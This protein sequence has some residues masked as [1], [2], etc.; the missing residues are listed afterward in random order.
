[1]KLRVWRSLALS[2]VL[3]AAL[4]SAATRP[5]YGGTL[6]LQLAEPVTM[7]NPGESKAAAFIH[8]VFETLVRIDE[9][10][11]PRP[12]LASGWQND[13]GFKRWQF[14]LRS[15]VTFHDGAPLNASDAQAS[16][17][18]VLP[19][20]TV[21][22]KRQ[23][24]V[25]ESTVPRP[26]LLRELAHP[27]AAI[28]RRAAEGG[29]VGTGPF[30]RKDSVLVSNQSYWGGRPFL[31]SIEF[32]AAGMPDVM[33]IPAN[34]TRRSI[35]ERL[36]IWT[37]APRDLFAIQTLDTAPVIGE[38]L[39]AGIDRSAIAK[40]L[41]LGRGVPT[42]ALLPQWMTGHA[43]LFSSPPDLPRARQM[44][45]GVRLRPLTLSYSSAD[46]LAKAIAERIAVNARDAG[47]SIQV[48]PF[49][50]NPHLRLARIRI[51][52][53]SQLAAEFGLASAAGSP[54]EAERAML[55]GGVVIP[56]LHVPD[57]FAIHPR[58]R[59]WEGAHESRDGLLHL[60]NVWIEP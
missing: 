48:S 12:H 44:L 1:M 3:L 51:E 23:I 58:V 38:A 14:D 31:D 42:G 6:R 29:L 2:S 57:V 27:R 5:R 39:S 56:L 50:P 28:V 60:E 18:E 20:T 10:G 11:G 53:L 19:D 8:L 24:L 15:R 36:S 49:A 45:A 25:I 59:G 55:Q 22:V 30:E 52:S 43:F 7:F 33:Q 41:T 40:V 26:N 54:Y 32:T 4:L 34:A 9:R 16:L 46:S 35:P 17:T 21:T 37:S 13:A 47:I